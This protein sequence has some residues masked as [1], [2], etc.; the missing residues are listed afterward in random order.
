MIDAV[1]VIAGLALLYAGGEALVR[2][3][4]ALARRLRVSKLVIGLVVVGFGTSMPELIVSIDAALAG[5]P[6][7]VLGTVVGSN[8]ANVL[9][10]VGT[11]AVIAPLAGWM[12]GAVRESMTLVAVTLLM[13][14]L[15]REDVIGRVQ[16]ALLLTG[17]V[18][19]LV[20]THWLERRERQASLHEIEAAAVEPLPAG[21]AS[22]ALLFVVGGLVG[23]VLGADLLVDGAVDLARLLGVSEA[24]IGLS[25][26]AIGTSLPE[27]AATVVAAMRRQ[28]DVVLG[29]VI[30]SC[31]F[32][33]LG[34]TGLT[35]TVQPLTVDPRFAG[36]DGIGL[37]LSAV[38]LALLLALR[39]S[40]GRLWGGTML[41]AYGAYVAFLYTNGAPS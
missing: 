5:T 39:P 29:N 41:I 18:A 13:Y 19:Y 2:G 24:V 38:L 22:Y 34:I 25:L 11:A 31:I 37:V 4:V 8:I 10:L 20:T 15:L 23:L 9:L 14:A 12:R 6:E 33:I 27:L 32:R 7:I 36:V 28:G 35:A 17:L 26:V 3:S 40:I 1:M 16:G 30:G 21:G